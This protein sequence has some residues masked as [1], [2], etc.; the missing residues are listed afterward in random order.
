MALN[1]L[2]L[3][4]GKTRTAKSIICATN[5]EGL[6]AARDHFDSPCFSADDL[7]DAFAVF[8]YLLIRSVRKK[9]DFSDLYQEHSFTIR[10]L[11][12]LEEYETAKLRV[13]VVTVFD[14]RKLGES[15]ASFEFK[16][17]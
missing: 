10:S 1:I 17:S 16:D 14:L 12:S 9:C 6:E 15:L 13:G 5:F 4:V 8:S 2:P 7:F 11:L 3:V